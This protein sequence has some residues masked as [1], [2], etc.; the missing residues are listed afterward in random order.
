M[1]KYEGF[2]FPGYKLR[3][4]FSKS[5]RFFF[6][7]KDENTNSCADQLLKLTN[8]EAFIVFFVVKEPNGRYRFMDASFRNLG[9]ESLEHFIVRYNQQLESMTRLSIQ[10]IGKEYV[11]AVGYSYQESVKS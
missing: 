9:A 7:C 3:E 2:V 11:E 5:H 4:W 6:D 1:A 8:F 10:T